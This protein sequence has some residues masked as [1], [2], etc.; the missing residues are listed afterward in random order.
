MGNKRFQ[1][2]A[3]PT[4]ARS[5]NND[6]ME[7]LTDAANRAGKA[8]LSDWVRDLLLDAARLVSKSA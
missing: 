4:P 2:N 5:P 8:T 1:T 7:K 3:F 6:E